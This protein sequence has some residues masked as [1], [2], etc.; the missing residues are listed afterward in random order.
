[1]SSTIYSSNTSVNRVKRSEAAEWRAS[2]V[3]RLCIRRRHVAASGGKLQDNLGKNVCAC[4]CV[5]RWDAGLQLR[6]GSV[7]GVDSGGFLLQVSSSWGTSYSVDGQQK[8]SA[9]LHAAGPPG[10]VP[11]CPSVCVSFG[12]QL[13]LNQ[14]RYAI[15]ICVCMFRGQRSSVWWLG[16]A[17][18]ERS[19]GGQRSWQ[20]VSIQKWPKWRILQTAAAWKLQLHSKQHTDT[21]CFFYL[22]TCLK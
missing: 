6:V 8:G 2:Q 4:V 16:S 22:H 5:C 1:M 3:L 13:K 11:V 18:A 15:T 21:V 12:N 17:G 19:G 7:S 9:G 14:E 10:S 20:H